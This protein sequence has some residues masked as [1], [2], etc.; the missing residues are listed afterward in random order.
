METPYDIEQWA[1]QITHGRH[2]FNYNYRMLGSEQKGWEL[3]KVV[4]MEAGPGV[5]DK[6][7]LWVNKDDP[8]REM[9]RVSIAEL[10]HWRLALKRLHEHLSNCM[11]PSIP[12]G[13]GKLAKLGDVAFV[14]R[15]PQ[16]D[17]PA[18]IFFTRGNVCVSVSSVGERN[19]DVSGVTAR[20]DRA[21]SKPPTKAEVEKGRVKARPPKAATVKAGEAQVLIK[22]LK[23]AARGGW[24][25]V[26]AP[27][28]QL[29]REGDALIYESS[30]GGK[31]RIGIY[32]S[33]S[34]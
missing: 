21:L 8:K 23:D 26:I 1:T 5:E 20:L 29:G 15:D 6:V 25:K 19:V 10:Y 33:P 16:L 13:T 14:A 3:L 22:N 11:R 9:A 12:R 17:L 7:Y 32:A 2:V 34:A 30:Q 4:T 28:G 18:A 27:D 31:K 24:L